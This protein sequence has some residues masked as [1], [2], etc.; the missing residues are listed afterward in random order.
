MKTGKCISDQA[1]K[2]LFPHSRNYR[3]LQF[4]GTKFQNG[5]IDQKR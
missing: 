3:K 1:K 5:N 2:A 4:L